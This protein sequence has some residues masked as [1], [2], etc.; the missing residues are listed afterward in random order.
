M[1]HEVRPK[2]IVE[3][4]HKKRRSSIWLII[5]IKNC[6]HNIWLIYTVYSVLIQLWLASNKIKV[7][8]A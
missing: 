8:L 2:L 1:L 7:I 5:L 3:I 6:G 4:G